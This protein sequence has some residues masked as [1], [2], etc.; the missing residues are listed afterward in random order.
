MSHLTSILA[1]SNGGGAGGGLFVGGMFIV[2]L[3]VVL[4]FFA[5]WLWMLIDVLQSSKPTNEKLLWAV[6][7]ILVGPLGSLIYFFI[8][9]GPKAGGAV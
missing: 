6:V 2:L 3:L 7:M 1:Q 4:A 8:A 9:R 5:F